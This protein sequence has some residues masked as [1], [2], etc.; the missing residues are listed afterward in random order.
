MHRCALETWRLAGLIAETL[1][2]IERATRAVKSLFRRI[3]ADEGENSSCSAMPSFQAAL[4]LLATTAA[5]V[6]QVAKGEVRL[7]HHSKELFYWSVQLVALTAITCGVLVLVCSVW[8]QLPR[9]RRHALQ[10]DMDW[11]DTIELERAQLQ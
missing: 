4:L 3:A 9:S 5:L 1:Q 10:Q 6:V 7:E 11:P 8:S 2:G